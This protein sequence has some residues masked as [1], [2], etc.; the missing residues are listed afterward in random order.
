MKLEELKKLNAAC[1]NEYETGYVHKEVSTVFE[2]VEKLIEIAKVMAS[3]C[4]H[5]LVRSALD[6]PQFAVSEGSLWKLLKF[7]RDELRALGADK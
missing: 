4:D 5:P 1:L 2:H 3:V 7:G 6:D